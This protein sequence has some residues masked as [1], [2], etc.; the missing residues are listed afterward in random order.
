MAEWAQRRP[1]TQRLIA[2]FNE[3]ERSEGSAGAPTRL[4]EMVDAAVS[5]TRIEE[6]LRS[7]G[8]LPIDGHPQVAVQLDRGGNP[9]GLSVASMGGHGRVLRK[10]FSERP[11]LLDTIPRHGGRLRIAY[12]DVEVRR[13]GDV[14]VAHLQ[15]D[16]A[17]PS[18]KN[19]PGRLLDEY[20][21]LCS[22]GALDKPGT[23]PG[24]SPK[25]PTF[26]QWIRGLP[27]SVFKGSSDSFYTMTT[28]GH[29]LTDRAVEEACR[30]P[31]T[32]ESDEPHS[33]LAALRR[34]VLQAPDDVAHPAPI[35]EQP[36][37]LTERS[38]EILD[39]GVMSA[40]VTVG[41][42]SSGTWRVLV[43]SYSGFYPG[44]VLAHW[45]R[46]L[47]AG[48]RRRLLNL[49]QRQLNGRVVA[50]P[51][52]STVGPRGYIGS[53]PTDLPDLTPAV[54]ALA[55][56]LLPP[57][58]E[59]IEPFR[60]D[61]RG[62]TGPDGFI[63]SRPGGG[64]EPADPVQAQGPEGAGAGGHL[65]LIGPIDPRAGLPDYTPP[66][67]D[68]RMR[69]ERVLREQWGS[70]ASPEDLVYRW[71]RR[72]AGNR[73][74]AVEERAAHAAENARLARGLSADELRALV[75]VWPEFVGKAGG[76]PRDV[77]DQ[78][79]RW[80]FA[81]TRA[82]VED[83]ARPTARERAMREYLLNVE[84]LLIRARQ[85]AATVATPGV[86][87]PTVLL[88]QFDA[89]RPTAGSLIISVGSADPL[90][91]AWHVDGTA[92]DLRRLDQRMQLAC[93]HY[94]AAVRENP[95]R[96]VR[97]VVWS[98]TDGHRLA[99]DMAALSADMHTGAASHPAVRPQ[100]QLVVHGNGGRSA[101][102]ALS[103]ESAAHTVD[104]V[105]VCG[106]SNLATMRDALADIA[107]SA[108]VYYGIASRA[109]S[110]AKALDLPGVQFACRFPT[111]DAGTT[112]SVLKD[113]RDKAQRYEKEPFEAG[114][115][116][117]DEFLLYI[118]DRTKAATESL[119]NMSRILAGRPDLVARHDDAQEAWVRFTDCIE[120]NVDAQVDSV[121]GAV[122]P[123]DP[124]TGRPTLVETAGD[125]ALA[126]S[127]IDK[128]GG[129]EAGP[130][131][132]LHRG[133][134][135]D[136]TRAGRLAVDNKRW[137][138][139]L[140]PDEQRAVVARYPEIVGNAPGIPSE[141]ANY[142][143]DYRRYAAA[144][145]IHAKGSRKAG[146]AGRQ[147]FRNLYAVDE[148]LIRSVTVHRDIPAPIVS[149]VALDPNAFG[150]NGS[151]TFV[152]GNCRLE[153]AEHV[154]WYADGVNT[155]LQSA[156]A[157]LGSA[158]NLY[159]ELVRADRASKVA[160]VCWIGYEAPANY[161]EA[162]AARPELAE[163][164][165]R[166]F[167]RDV[168][169]LRAV[170]NA[171][172]S[173]LG[174]S[175]G[176]PVVSDATVG[177]RLDHI[178]GNRTIVGSPGRG[179]RYD[180]AT[181]ASCGHTW[182]LAQSD[183]TVT[184]L[185]GVSPD[186]RG[187]LLG[188]GPLG[189]GTDPATDTNATRVRA[190]RGFPYSLAPYDGHG[191]YLQYSL[192]GAAQPTES[193]RYAAW[194][195]AGR[196]AEVP[197]E[198]HRPTVDNPTAM[199]RIRAAVVDAA[200][201][202]RAPQLEAALDETA[203]HAA[204]DPLG[205]RRTDPVDAGMAA[206]DASDTARVGPRIAIQL[207]AGGLAD[208]GRALTDALA[209]GVHVV[210]AQVGRA[211][212]DMA[213]LDLVCRSATF[214]DAALAVEVPAGPAWSDAEVRAQ[215]REVAAALERHGVRGELHAVDLRVLAA[216]AEVTPDC[217]C[218]AMINS[219]TVA[220]RGMRGAAGWMARAVLPGTN[221]IDAIL[222][223][224]RGAGA[225]GI[226]VPYPLLSERFVRQ[227]DAA[228]MR[229]AV[230]GVAGSGRMRA[231][232]ALGVGEIW[233]RSSEHLALLRAEV[234]E[235]GFRIPEA[236]SRS[237]PPHDGPPRATPWSGFPGR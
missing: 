177:G 136:F 205:A 37:P 123:R 84:D 75:L 91:E 108:D 172:F 154:V 184:G 98:G 73:A 52:T 13:D 100:R 236:F 56:A 190:E 102:K 124:D 99:G 48:H 166:M 149:T 151:G 195:L 186:A 218:V 69:A 88:E 142:A 235:S 27:P 165:G 116:I 187:R 97:V 163:A 221:D 104:T 101:K 210:V 208:D 229:L 49:I 113:V 127:A 25:R 237:T 156:T 74:V 230:S 146:R 199:H 189:L 67:A 80:A 82:A 42:D 110:P 167:A 11:D 173:V 43:P 159:E 231:A 109:S 181:D 198:Q 222:E 23:K 76:F 224:V 66:D 30:P 51:A 107:S 162:W 46:Q 39:L 17:D 35:L 55:Q 192:V 130:D 119:N 188:D 93:N 133:L 22:A 201:D 203:G 234:A 53:R 2:A 233:A 144:A 207:G 161:K 214:A 12:D 114:K 174:Y 87:I 16:D 44:D 9:T 141:V 155:R 1:D 115:P 147:I 41:K 206:A 226:A 38:S 89:D 64:D 220:T 175:Y 28:H 200:R 143:N 70:G 134:P 170:S 160:V 153:D 227:A 145:D 176:T 137:W 164:G 178:F 209:L 139:A 24:R 57:G 152:I 103:H 95:D 126:R 77:R 85:R 215:V 168:Q 90:S 96:P 196:G 15:P 183:D 26:E 193:L 169:A 31:R 106:E 20:L 21:R 72:P 14:R 217:R 232:I 59:M 121:Y 112:N 36:A 158:R 83:S 131:V 71:R 79:N 125:G 29:I 171:R 122:L 223:E 105:V 18:R 111:G 94:E 212:A 4:V 148:A 65:H 81:K 179:R 68:L 211:A 194:C 61:G 129:R 132:L 86:P 213:A 185:G 34:V 78:A 135:D 33:A 5:S 47:H 10:L 8:A 157:R 140:S 219:L 45:C 54:T 150:G 225:S 216:A 19:I 228:D 50:E 197:T 32:S 138:D 128:R 40:R 6:A 3:W 7:G 202:R 62:N 92:G 180:S 118:D 191:E 117:D 60:S 58:G 63:G 182:V 204:T 120:R